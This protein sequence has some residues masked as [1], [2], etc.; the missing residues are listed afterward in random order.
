MLGPRGTIK[1]VL[2]LFLTLAGCGEVG[3]DLTIS[4][5]QAEAARRSDSGVLIDVR[6][7]SEVDGPIPGA[8]A[9]PYMRPDKGGNDDA[10]TMDVEMASSGRRIMLVCLYGVRSQW[11][12]DALKRRG[13]DSVSIQQGTRKRPG[14]PPMLADR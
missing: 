3:D 9:V 1:P 11:A 4:W 13:V 7:P 10:F 14:P 5:E 6:V 8:I 12:R 2:V